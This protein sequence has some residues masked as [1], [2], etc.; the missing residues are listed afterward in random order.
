L[1]EA[2]DQNWNSRGHFFKAAAETMRRILIENTR[3]KKSQKHGGTYQRV[4]LETVIL[5]ITGAF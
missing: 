4:N 1:V 5:S 3:R 2:E